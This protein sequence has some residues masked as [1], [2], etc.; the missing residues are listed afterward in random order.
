VLSEAEKEVYEKLAEQD[1]QRYEREKKD[2]DAKMAVGWKNYAEEK[3]AS[4][5]D[6]FPDK[7]E[8][9]V[10]AVMDQAWRDLPGKE[11]MAFAMLDIKTEHDDGTEETEVEK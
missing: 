9:F 10:E 1:Q 8:E 5:R 11:R 3:R 7:S 4:V 6:R 2:Y